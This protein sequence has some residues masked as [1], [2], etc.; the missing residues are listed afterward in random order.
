MKEVAKEKKICAGMREG[1]GGRSEAI[2]QC[3]EVRW[4]WKSSSWG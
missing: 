3:M 1:E 4:W 2:G